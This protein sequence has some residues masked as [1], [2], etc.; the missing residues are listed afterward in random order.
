MAMNSRGEGR[1]DRRLYLWHDH[2]AYNASHRATWMIPHFLTFS[3][4]E[5]LLLA[6]CPVPQSHANSVML[7][8]SWELA[9]AFQDAMRRGVEN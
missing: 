4:S 1:L 9:L 5:Q 3:Y 2:P 7:C 6:L 8:F